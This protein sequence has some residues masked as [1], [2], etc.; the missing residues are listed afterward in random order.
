ME[1]PQKP[2]DVYIRQRRW[3]TVCFALLALILLADAIALPV[4]VALR[5]DENWSAAFQTGF[6]AL[7]CA[8]AVL[9]GVVLLA[10]LL[11]LCMKLPRTFLITADEKGIY[12]YSSLVP[13]GFIPWDNVANVEYYGVF[14]FSQ[15]LFAP[16]AN[17][18]K[19]TLRSKADFRK[20]LRW[21]QRAAFRL[22]FSRL[23]VSLV[24][25]KGKGA[26]IGRALRTMR[27]YYA[28]RDDSNLTG[29]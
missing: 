16:D 8:A 21:F 20:R 28:P 5:P 29:K 10:V 18:I 19:L 13:Y 12:L 11:L 1:K 24:L 23:Y 3:A 15:D 2:Q 25:C 6:F 14:S 17:H 27:E 4:A 26:E 22:N 7:S 9:F